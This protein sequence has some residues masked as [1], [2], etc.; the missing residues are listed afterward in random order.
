MQ[1]NGGVPVLEDT[2]LMT[3]RLSTLS[4]SRM[5][6]WMMLC[7]V[8]AQFWFGV[9]HASAGGQAAYCSDGSAQR[10]A[11][12]AAQLPPELRLPIAQLDGSLPGSCTPSASV[13]CPAL[14]GKAVPLALRVDARHERP[15][16]QNRPATPIAFTRQPPGTGPPRPA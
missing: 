5:A 2:V 10:G 7:A 8:L 9:L 15:L 3:L 4:R 16:P 13:C 14:A 11:A 1:V 6:S 12:L